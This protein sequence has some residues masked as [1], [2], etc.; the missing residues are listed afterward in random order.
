MV[1]IGSI[2]GTLMQGNGVTGRAMVWECRLAPM[3]AVILA[4]SSTA[5]S[6]DSDVTILGEFLLWCYVL[7]TVK[8]GFRVSNS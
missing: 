8:R 6:T 4:S 2:Q 5:S 3:V 7:L 1:F